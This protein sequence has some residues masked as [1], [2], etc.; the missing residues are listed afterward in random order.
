M[1]PSAVSRVAVVPHRVQFPVEVAG[2]VAHAVTVPTLTSCPSAVAPVNPESPWHGF[3]ALLQVLDTVPAVVQS[4]SVVL[5]SQS[6][7]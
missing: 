3:D 5:N 6:P 4:A 1:S 7:H 2:Y